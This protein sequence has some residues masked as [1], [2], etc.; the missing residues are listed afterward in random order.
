MPP[1]LRQAPALPQVQLVSISEEDAGQRIDN[2]LLRVCK[3]VPK[4]HIY[5]VLRS[6][7]VRVNKGRI[8]LA[9]FVA[10]T[11]TNPAKL[12]GLYPRKGTLAVGSDA[13]LVIW[14]SDR[15]VT[16]TN[17]LLHHNCDYTPYEGMR[18]RGWPALVLSR[19]E[20]VVDEGKLTAEPG[21]GHFL[22]CGRPVPAKPPTSRTRS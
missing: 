15:D 1:Q 7:E 12:Y 20:V 22:K 18:V 10:L 21:Q 19:G 13:D 16:I 14:D 8:D 5:R 11:A 9:T 17:D 2:F 3:G 6:G 4:S